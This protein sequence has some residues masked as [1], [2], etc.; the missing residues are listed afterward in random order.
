[1]QVD[2]IDWSYNSISYRGKCE[3]MCFFFKL[4]NSLNGGQ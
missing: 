1:M 3:R 2:M 4:Y